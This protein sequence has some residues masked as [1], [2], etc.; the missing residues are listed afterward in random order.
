VAPLLSAITVEVMDDT[1]HG[2]LIKR[3]GFGGFVSDS[4]KSIGFS[5]NLKMKRRIDPDR[6]L[7]PARV[8]SFVF[9]L[10]VKAGD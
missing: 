4:V 3:L 2:N 5:R 7:S 9:A 1:F 8:A 10:E 6:V